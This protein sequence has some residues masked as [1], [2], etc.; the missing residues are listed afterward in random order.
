LKEQILEKPHNKAREAISVMSALA[1]EVAFTR[2]IIP[3]FEAA[4][5]VDV[6][7]LWDPTTVLMRRIENGERADVIVAISGSMKALA[8]SKIVRGQ[9]VVEIA[10]VGLGLAVKSGAPH[11]AIATSREFINTLTNAR[12]VAYS[13]GGASGIYFSELIARLGIADQINTRAV[14]IPAGFTAEKVASGEADLAVQQISELMSVE[15]VE[16]I[17]PFPAEYQKTTNFSA[18]VFSDAANPEGAAKFI[19]ALRTEHSQEAYRAGGLTS[20]VGAT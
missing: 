19:Q 6:R 10:Q 12:A 1:V 14:T 8:D 17:G 16:V 5:N 15:G 20:L 3:T 4:S 7:I 18:A 11:P 9:S 2:S 13:K